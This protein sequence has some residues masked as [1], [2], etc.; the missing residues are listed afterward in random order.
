VVAYSAAQLRVSR[1]IREALAIDA[2]GDQRRTFPVFQF[3]GV[4]LEI[5][6]VQ[7]ARRVRLADRMV[8]TVNRMDLRHI[9]AMAV[10]PHY[11]ILIPV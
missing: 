5:S 1:P 10:L 11:Y 9:R 6:F 3:A 7:I 8:S 4:P 2:F